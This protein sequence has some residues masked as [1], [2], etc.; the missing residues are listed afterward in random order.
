MINNKISFIVNKKNIKK[1]KNLEQIKQKLSQNFKLEF[2]YTESIGDGI[3]KARIASENGTN[4]VVAIGGDGTINEVTNGILTSSVD[5]KP[6]LS[7]FPCGTGND[8]IK[9]LTV[10]PII[11]SFK[12][13]KT[14]EL[15]ILKIEYTDENKNKKTRYSINIAN[16]G[17]SALTVKI[18]NGSKK[19]LGSALTFFVGA[20]KAFL[21]YKHNSVEITGDNFTYKGK[22]TTVVFANGKYF[23]GGMCIAPD[24]ILNDG[25]F[26]ITLVGEVKTLTFLKYIT[27]LRKNKRIIHP[28]VFYDKTKKLSIKNL[29]NQESPLEADGEFLGYTPIDVSISTKKI[30]VLL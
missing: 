3:T 14:T 7:I 27:K 26:N 23:G 4:F 13:L 10:K 22:I 6:I 9:S 15:D 30:I 19:R 25:F 17:V 12:N 16:I 24:A 29:S 18:V 1:C 20:L 8:F 21:T 28:E 5:K 11:E 2:L